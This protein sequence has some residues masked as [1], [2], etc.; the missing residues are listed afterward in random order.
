MASVVDNSAVSPKLASIFACILLSAPMKLTVAWASSAERFVGESF[1][2]AMHRHRPERGWERESVADT[3]V[4]LADVDW[5]SV[6]VLSSD[7]MA[8]FRVMRD[9]RFL[10]EAEAPE[11]PR[12]VPWLYPRDGCYA[13]AAAVVGLADRLGLERPAQFFAFGE[14]TVAT[15]N[16][17]E[18]EVRWWYH[19]T[20][21]YRDRDEG[22][23]WV[24]DPS[25]EPLRPIAVDDWL[26]RMVPSMEDVRVALCAAL[27]SE[28][29]ADC[30]EGNAD[31]PD[32][33]AALL[34]AHFLP[35]E[36]QNLSALGRDPYRELGDAPPWLGER[37]RSSS[38]V[39]SPIE[40]TARNASCTVMSSATSFSS[41]TSK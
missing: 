34:R 17:A 33:L 10:V 37:G 23:V 12:R 15:P 40:S 26:S 13:R 5:S 7:L 14:L 11:F 1:T 25:I 39:T 38:D 41:S 3:T 30:R 16:V 21:V 8:T 18:G 2:Q 4:P 29:N 32:R 31:A 27:A 20:P 24:F 19:V 22:R 6:P 36:W 28:P 35:F 9:S